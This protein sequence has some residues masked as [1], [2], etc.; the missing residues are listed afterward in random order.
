MYGLIF[1]HLL[2]YISIM[3]KNIAVLFFLSIYSFSVFAQDI[4]LF[5]IERNKNDNIVCYDLNV[6]NGK[7]NT[8]NPINIYWSN[9][10]NTS[11][12]GNGLSSI[13]RKLAY[14]ITVNSVSETK[15]VFTMKASSDRVIT[16]SFDSKEKKASPVTVINGEKAILKKMFIS[17]KAPLYTSVVY[18]EL[19]GKSVDSAKDL[20]EKINN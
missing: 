15:V 9:L 20:Y 7:I 12:K 10:S 14:G 16:V 3:I 2:F 11:F 13:E 5:H 19:F 4:R 18:A 1:I 8:T 6:E 17:A